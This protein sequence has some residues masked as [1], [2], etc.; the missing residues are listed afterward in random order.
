ME[1]ILIANYN[2]KF[3]K[4]FPIISRTIF[5]ARFEIFFYAILT[6]IAKTATA[7]MSNMTYMRESKVCSYV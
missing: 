7:I 4:N 2:K 3:I 6:L 5:V 1:N